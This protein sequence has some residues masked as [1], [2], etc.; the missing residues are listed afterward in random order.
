MLW[1]CSGH[2]H[3]GLYGFADFEF[4]W[5][6]NVARLEGHSVLLAFVCLRVALPSNFPAVPAEMDVQCR[7][8]TPEANCFL[9]SP[10][11]LP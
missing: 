6:S 5:Q 9:C 1:S 10:Y 3:D 7:L 2:W 4:V 8:L 11:R